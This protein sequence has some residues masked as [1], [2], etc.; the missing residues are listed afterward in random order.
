MDIIYLY[1]NIMEEIKIMKK[2]IYTLILA[3]L[4]LEQKQMKGMNQ[5]AS[6]NERQKGNSIFV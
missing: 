3:L 1:L 4:V 6:V 2:Y 5:E